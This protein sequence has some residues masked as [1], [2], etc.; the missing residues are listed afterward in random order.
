MQI[1]KMNNNRVDK[2]KKERE[3]K[4]EKKQSTFLTVSHVSIIKI[5]FLNPPLKL[6]FKTFNNFNTPTQGFLHFVTPSFYIN[7]L[8]I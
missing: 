1:Y 4:K 8:P 3:K 6:Y 2:K 5:N 7:I